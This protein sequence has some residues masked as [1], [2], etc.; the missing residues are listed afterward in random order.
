MGV[1][2]SPDMKKN[3]DKLKSEASEVFYL[4]MATLH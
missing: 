4:N 3:V 2:L 1:P